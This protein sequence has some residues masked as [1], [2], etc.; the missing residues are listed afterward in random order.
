MELVKA[1]PDPETLK[2]FLWIA[3]GVITLLLTIVGFFLRRELFGMKSLNK[4][5]KQEWDAYAESQS[6]KW[7]EFVSDQ[8]EYHHQQH[9]QICKLEILINTVCSS[10]Q[11][12]NTI[13]EVIRRLDEERNPRIEKQVMEHERRL[14][15]FGQEL[16]YIKEKIGNGFSK[17]IL[18]S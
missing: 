9:E 4:Q 7:K 10:M 1:N 12:I 11:G 14:V 16:V 15:S 18:E 6:K 17:S 2:M 5:Y 3:I 13:V 8:K